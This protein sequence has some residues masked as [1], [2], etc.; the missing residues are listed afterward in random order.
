MLFFLRFFLALLLAWILRHAITIDFIPTHRI[1][2]TPAEVA[3]I[4]FYGMN[5]L[6]VAAFYDT[7]VVSGAVAV[8]VDKDN[9]SGTW[10]V[11]PAFELAVL[12][13]P[14]DSV[15]YIGEFRN[16]PS[17]YITA[18]ICT[19]RYEART[20]WLSA[21]KAVPAP[22][23]SAVPVAYLG[24]GYLYDICTSN[25]DTFFKACKFFLRINLYGST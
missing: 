3:A 24:S 16:C 1:C 25:T 8:P 11:L 13:E 23:L 4:A 20:P 5:V 10:L 18:L 2:F 19:P 21:A 6:A 9:V 15:R 22:E 14:V 12:L 17:L 7:Y